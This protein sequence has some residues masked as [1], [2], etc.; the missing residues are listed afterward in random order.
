MTESIGNQPHHPELLTESDYPA[1]SEGWLGIFRVK[2]DFCHSSYNDPIVYPGAEGA[3]HLHRFYGNTLEDHNTTV[4][5]C[6]QAVKG[7]VKETYSTGP[8]IG[9]PH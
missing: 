2:C 9:H 6:L 3:A 7:L 8:A 4:K 5:A 1:V